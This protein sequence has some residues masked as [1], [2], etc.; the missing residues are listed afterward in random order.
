MKGQCEDGYYRNGLQRCKMNGTG[1]CPM[2]D[3]NIRGVEPSGSA[4][5]V[6]ETNDTHQHKA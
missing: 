5:I 4:T 1:L 6:L 3:L 2:V